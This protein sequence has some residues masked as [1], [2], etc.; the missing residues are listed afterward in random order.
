MLLFAV[1]S[2]ILAFV[3]SDLPFDVRR[4]FGAL[5]ALA[6]IVLMALRAFGRGPMRGLARGPL[7]VGLAGIALA[8]AISF[9]RD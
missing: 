8:V 2:P 9:L 6:G 1:A 4:T 3:G 7:V 5:V